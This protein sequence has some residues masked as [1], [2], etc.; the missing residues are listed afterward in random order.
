MAIRIG[1]TKDKNG[2]DLIIFA[3]MTLANTPCVA[4]FFKVYSEI[5]E[6]GW[7][8][9][10]VPFN[11]DSRVIWLERPNGKIVGGVC[12]EYTKH[13]QMSWIVLT[14][15]DPDE[16]GKGINTICQKELEKI[17]K[18]LGAVQICSLIH[19]DNRAAM[20]SAEKVGR[21]PQFYR[22]LKRI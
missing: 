2:D 5:L 21:K 16:R 18:K 22:M 10:T 3:S 4:L 14:F 17:S 8:N 12:Y 11:N 7:A 19:V 13:N 20:A 9:P 6:N 15:T 1:T